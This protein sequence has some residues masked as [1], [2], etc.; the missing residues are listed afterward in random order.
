MSAN[1]MAM[2]RRLGLGASVVTVVVV[3][4]AAARADLSTF[5]DAAWLTALD[6]LT[7]WLWIVAAA[8]SKLP[9][10][11]RLLAGGVGLTWLLGSFIG[12]VVT[13]H[14][15]VL[16][17]ALL[18]FPSG[19][20]A[21]RAIWLLVA[22]GGLMALGLVPQLGVAAVF[23]AAMIVTLQRTTEYGLYP[24]LSAAA[25]A[26]AVTLSW[27]SVHGPG[28]VPE[29]PVVYLLTV[30]AIGAVFPFAVRDRR[31][32]IESADRLVAGGHRGAGLSGLQHVLREVL[33][34]PTLNIQLWD[35]SRQD[36]YADGPPGRPGPTYRSVL[37][38]TV[39]GVPVARVL[40]TKLALDNPGTRS[41]VA[42]AIALSMA[43]DRLRAAE[44]EQLR[45][46]R[47]SS[48]RLVEAGDRE[49]EHLANR[50]RAD[51]DRLLRLAR[52]SLELAAEGSDGAQATP[53][54]TACAEVGAASS[55]LGRL[56]AGIPL[57]PLGEG[58]LK[59]AV[60]ALTARSTVPVRTRWAPDA[61]ADCSGET[62][63]FYVVCEGLAN[64]TKHSGA[65]AVSLDV[66]R[67][68]GQLVLTL[69][70]D[71]VGNAEP[72]GSGLR[73]LSDRMAAV[74]GRL[75]VANVPTGGTV[76]TAEVPVSSSSV[77]C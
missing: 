56:V 26:A 47:R 28:D 25:L 57:T 33:N 54:R 30:G 8:V 72:G 43:N 44:D 48:A 53:L 12:F 64:V 59:D 4:W 14:Q 63:L 60:A 65:R 21:G 39:D 13:L 9:L 67:D 76:L 58:R 27:W 6:L 41:G 2:A 37:P 11:E 5:Q 49:R 52:A 45:A 40:A 75:T 7:G 20:P 32:R 77:R 69:E 19:R 29:G 51:V 74:G 73:G 62:S 18:A 17:V 31:R 50:L 35:P 23:V 38:V 42:H 70:D 1:R 68:G 46:L 61:R 24:P 55:E 3:T 16:L 36:W 71:G 10:S 22:A 15:A 66:V 34:D